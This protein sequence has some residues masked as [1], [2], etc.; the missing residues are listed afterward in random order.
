[1]CNS[2]K[3]K[4]LIMECFLLFTIFVS[5]ACH[6]AVTN[7]TTLNPFG[8]FATARNFTFVTCESERIS[9]LAD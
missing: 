5:F 3:N 7:A 4:L 2:I 6:Q 8:L 1:M 9:L